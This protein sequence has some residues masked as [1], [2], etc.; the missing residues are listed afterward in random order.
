MMTNVK[1][2]ISE[3][4]S[5]EKDMFNRRIEIDINDIPGIKAVKYASGCGNNPE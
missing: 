2:H 3:P 5:I 4:I 1:T